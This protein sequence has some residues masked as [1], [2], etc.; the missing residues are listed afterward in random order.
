[1]RLVMNHTCPSILAVCEYTRDNN[2][3]FKTHV[4]KVH[5]NDRSLSYCDCCGG[6]GFKR[7]YGLTHKKVVTYGDEANTCPY[8]EKISKKLS[9]HL[10]NKKACRRAQRR[11]LK[12]L[13]IALGD[14]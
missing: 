12:K 1:M 5:H 3:H 2:T 8:C 4:R 13:K 14:V 10:R 11:A 6:R 7:N 9:T